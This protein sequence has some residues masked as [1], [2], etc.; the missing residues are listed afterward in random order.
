MLAKCLPET[1]ANTSLKDAPNAGNSTSFLEV[2][3]FGAEEEWRCPSEYE[4]SARNTIFKEGLAASETNMRVDVSFEIDFAQPLLLGFQT[5][6]QSLIVKASMLYRA[7]WVD[8]RLAT[9]P[10]RKVLSEALKVESTSNSAERAVAS[11]LGGMHWLPAVT[12][13][14]GENGGNTSVTEASFYYNETGVP[15][16]DENNPVT[17]LDANCS[18]CAVLRAKVVATITHPEL[19]FSLWPFDQHL[20]EIVV[21]LPK[22]AKLSSCGGALRDS[23]VA[24]S[25]WGALGET[26]DTSALTLEQWEAKLLPATK[27]WLLVEED[28]PPHFVPTGESHSC[29]LEITIRRSATVYVVKQ[30]AITIVFVVC[31]LLALLMAPAELTGD[32]VATILFSALL[33]STN[34]QA[35]KGL[36]SLQYI[37][38]RALHQLPLSDRLCFRVS[39]LTALCRIDVFNL[40]QIFVLLFV[41]LESI[42]VHKQVVQQRTR[43]AARLDAALLPFTLVLYII[44]LFALFSFHISPTACWMSIAVLVPLLLIASVSGYVASRRRA[45]RQRAEALRFL[46]STSADDDPQGFREALRQ[47]FAAFDSEQNGLDIDQLRAF[48]TAVYPSAGKKDIASGMQAARQMFD[49]NHTISLENFELVLESQL[50]GLLGTPKPAPLRSSKRWAWGGTK[51]QP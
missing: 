7:Q 3:D 18:H 9:A 20:I 47:L 39:A 31:G 2:C 29:R 45:A 5:S 40:V 28:S 49:E 33:V 23:S 46:S 19:D 4:L 43:S 26:W 17:S 27:E 41:L 21:A 50:Q 1:L 10:C 6:D 15:F 24:G 51:V 14:A 48:L 13:T 11:Q 8:S 32:R 34:M 38:W 44:L 35:D 37:M 30:L 25:T 22:T 12:V 36:G 16:L 42:Y